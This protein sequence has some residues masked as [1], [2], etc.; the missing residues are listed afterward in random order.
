MNQPRSRYFILSIDGGGCRG[1]IPAMLLRA[2]GDD[3]IRRMDLYAGTST[4]AILAGGLACGIGIDPIAA[5]YLSRHENRTTF[6]PYS[7]ITIPFIS[8]ALEPRYASDGVKQ[9]VGQ[10]AETGRALGSL[11]RHC[12]MPSF[13]IDT[14][15][16]D[17]VPQWSATAFHNLGSGAGLGGYPDVSVLDAIL[18]STAAPMFFPP[19]R[20]GP[21]LFI[22][23]GVAAANPSMSAIAAAS[24]AGVIGGGGVALDNVFMLSLGT[25]HSQSGYPPDPPAL[26][27]A[28]GMLG[29]MWPE[30]RGSDT[31]GMPV[32][33]AASDG[34]AQLTDYQARSILG[35]DNYRRAQLQFG[36]ASFPMDDYSLL[37]GPE[38]LIARTETYMKSEEWREIATWVGAKLR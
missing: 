26:L 5:V 24:H 36:P 17:G 32:I 8:H 14:R 9:V 25:G 21:L 37:E 30:P 12:F 11:D 31:P 38:G 22:D 35:P 23:G 34:V 33:D 7:A 13:V 16:P 1:V 29:W 4:G 28:Y 27:P 2:L 20:I 19:H 6:T 15:A 18:S 3:L 10:F